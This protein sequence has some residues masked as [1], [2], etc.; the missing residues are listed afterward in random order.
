MW[1]TTE[2]RVQFG[3]HTL[4]LRPATRETSQSI[5][6]DLDHIS[7]GQALTLINQFLSVL[8]WCDDQP[9][10]NKYGWSGNPVPVSVPNDSRHVGSSVAFPFGRE[11][12][13]NPQARLALALFREARTINSV[14]LSFLS[15]F[16]ILN[17]FWDDK[18]QTRKGVQSIRLLKES[19]L[20]CQHSTTASR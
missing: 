18:F 1:P 14:P 17:I 5:H 4:V 7:D 6:V 11:L 8:S 20:P 12:E 15:Y 9:M 13:S 3:G 16:K 19:D 2:T 10:E